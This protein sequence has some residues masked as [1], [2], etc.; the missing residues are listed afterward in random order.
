M[1]STKAVKRSAAPGC[2]R[3]CGW[4]VGPLS[5]Q[6]AGCRGEGARAR[7]SSAAHAREHVAATLAPPGLPTSA[8]THTHLRQQQGVGLGCPQEA[9]DGAGAAGAGGCGSTQGLL[10]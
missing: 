8:H 9:G 7:L 5:A 6:S 3:R 10:G 1:I 4:L 2:C